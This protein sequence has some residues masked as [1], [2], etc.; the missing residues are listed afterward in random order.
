MKKNWIKLDYTKYNV[1]WKEASTLYWCGGDSFA[2]ART[3]YDCNHSKRMFIDFYNSNQIN[4]VW[5]AEV[6]L[7]K[8]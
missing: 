4:Q 1:L 7:Q 2:I 3:R 8:F 5:Q 6:E